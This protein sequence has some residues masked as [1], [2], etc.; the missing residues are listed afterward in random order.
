MILINLLP[1]ELRKKETVKLVLPDLPVKKTVIAVGVLLFILQALLSSGA[2]YSHWREKNLTRELALMNDEARE[3][4]DLKSQTADQQKKLQDIRNLTDKK[5]YWA[6]LLNAVT[7]SM[8]QGVWLRKLSL[9]ELTEEL[10]AEA[11]PAANPPKKKAPAP[12]QVRVLKLEGSVVAV[13]QE[14]AF[15]G[16]FVKALKDDVYLAELFRDIELSAINQRKIKDNDV[17]DFI[18]FCKFKKGKI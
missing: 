12:R 1:Q 8:T 16:R 6:S 9:D 3:T 14:A 4:H 13:G 7:Q 11:V 5:F 17:Y 18:L 10:P 2:A 15:I